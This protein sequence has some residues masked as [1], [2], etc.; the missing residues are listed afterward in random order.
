M[1]KTAAISSIAIRSVF[2]SRVLFVMF[3]ILGLCIFGIPL[4]VKGDGTLS[5]HFRIMLN[6]TLSAIT[7]ILSIATLW[8]GCAALAQDIQDHQIQ[9]VVTKPVRKWEIWLGK[10]L[11]L[12][13]IN[14][15]LVACSGLVLYISLCWT[16]RFSALTEAQTRKLHEEI[17]VTRQ[18]IPHEPPDIEA[19]AHTQAQTRWEQGGLP[20]HI[21]FAEVLRAARYDIVQR[22]YTVAPQSGCHWTFSLRELSNEHPLLFRYRFASSAIGPDPVTGYWTIYRKEDPHN[23]YTLE[24]TSTPNRTHS[25]TAP[26]SLFTAPGI[27]RVEYQNKSNVPVIVIFPPEN[28]LELLVYYGPFLMNFVRALSLIF[29]HLAFLSAVGLTAGTLFSLPVAT[30]ISAYTLVLIKFYPSIHQPTIR[31]FMFEEPVSISAALLETVTKTIFKILD[32]LSYPLR[33]TIPLDILASGRLIPWSMVNEQFV[34]QMIVYSG[35]MACLASWIFNKKEI[36]QG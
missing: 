2:R 22:G 15:A 17:M 3:A 24:T 14:A 23:A 19:E 7:M 5:G 29:F 9:L 8:S 6:Y 31:S 35:C 33:E 36:A 34:I 32:L 4:T 16:L 27:L 28:G 13:A 25:F 1:T 30:L 18:P 26:A 12:L 20:E 10:W 11:G 21:R